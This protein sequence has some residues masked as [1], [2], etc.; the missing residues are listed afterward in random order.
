M[1]LTL[2]IFFSFFSVCLLLI[3]NYYKSLF[4]IDKDQYQKQELTD[5]KSIFLHEYNQI[6]NNN[7][8][9]VLL[10]LGVG[11]LLALIMSYLSHWILPHYEDYLF[12]SVI[13]P[14]FFYILFPILQQ[15]KDVF[16]FPFLKTIL[17]NEATFF[18]G[19]CSLTMGKILTVFFI[20]YKI[21]FVWIFLNYAGIIYLFSDN[22]KPIN[23][24]FLELVISSTNI[25]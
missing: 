16:K 9:Q 5:Y 7:S 3:I 13:I 15:K 12:H 2:L 23:I 8:S 10:V 17:E 19:I 1:F 22:I 20:Y 25:Y 4:S 6:T 18:F 24:N 11:S 14:L 21:H